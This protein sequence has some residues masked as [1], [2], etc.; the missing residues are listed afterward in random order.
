MKTPKWLEEIPVLPRFW[1]GVWFATTIL[2]ALSNYGRALVGVEAGSWFPF[3]CNLLVA[4]ILGSVLIVSRKQSPPK[5]RPLSSEAQ[6]A[7]KPRP[8]EELVGALQDSVHKNVGKA[9][10]TRSKKIKKTPKA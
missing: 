1:L 2:E 8:P 7:R 6:E 4:F 3:G 5:R 9:R 10:P